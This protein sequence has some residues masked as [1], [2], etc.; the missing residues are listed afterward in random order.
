MFETVS[1]PTAKS[2]AER[3]KDYRKKNRDRD[4]ANREREKEARKAAQY[5][6]IPFTAWDGEGVTTESGEHLYTL[7]ANS[8]GDSIENPAG[9]TTAQ[10]LPWLWAN[11]REG[12]IN[13]IYG[14]GY[15]WNMWLHSLTR[16]EAEILYNEPHT[17][18]WGKWR[19]QWMQGR[20]FAL[21]P[22]GAKAPIVF[23]DVLPFFQRSFVAACDEYL[24]DRFIE[25]ERIVFNKQRRS[26]FDAEDAE[27]VKTY[28][29]AE[30][31]NLVNLMVEFRQRLFNAGLPRLTKW[32]GPGALA[33]AVLDEHKM[34]DHIVDPPVNAIDPIR[35]AYYGGRFEV[36]KTGHT[37]SPVYEYDLN[38][39][40]PWGLL[41][42][43]SLAH[44]EWIHHAHDV[45]DAN[46][47]TVYHVIYR[48]NGN[49]HL[50]QP[51]PARDGKT[52][53][54]G[55][56]NIAEG[57]YWKPE[58]D[59]ARQ[60]VEEYG[61]SLDILSCWEFVPTD[62]VRPFAFVQE[63]YDRR[64]VLKAN[65]DGAHV[66][67]KLA[68]NSLY[69]K[70]A[71]QVGWRTEPDGTIVK[72]PF[73]CLAYAG[74][75]TSKCRAA[76]LGA[77]LDDLSTVIAW[78]TDAVFTTTP[79]PLDTTTGLG[80]WEE[81]IFTEGLTYLQSGTYFSGN[82]TAKSRGVDRGTLTHGDVMEALI[83]GE[84]FVPATLTRF[85]TLGAALQ[86][87]ETFRKWCRWITGDKEVSIT[88]P[89]KRVHFPELCPECKAGKM[90]YQCLHTTWIPRWA[91]H[92]V[93]APFPVEWLD[94]GDPMAADYARFKREGYEDDGPDDF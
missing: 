54:V 68:L 6:S 94:Q 46:V 51:L 24:G 67:L 30:L 42:L 73:H 65:G 25:R 75:L 12:E 64:Q 21:R 47:L 45:R 7:L 58:I 44:G 20:M 26:Q 48:S 14:A 28:N 10:I 34:R 93:A 61:G 23:Y 53:N 84:R 5:L 83:M 86:G 77:V 56:P 52:G 66:G 91:R 57:W 40:Y 39:A 4:A 49:Q 37:D 17:L 41:D 62:S 8:H 63:Y 85:I 43:P 19:I 80:K 29:D 18:W 9:L 11:A 1:I 38:S 70:T 90:L 59:M 87:R 71:Q 55:F 27:D 50:P 32:Y 22:R 78:E 2:G 81:S 72:P 3:V 13:V 31:S 69:G 79:L 33:S 36:I 82:S 89:G 16:A 92:I 74:Y 15:D 60:Y 88:P 35:T 76:V